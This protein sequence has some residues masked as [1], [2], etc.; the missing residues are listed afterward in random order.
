MCVCVCVCVCVYARP[1]A[2]VLCGS[3]A[4][5]VVVLRF[6]RTQQTLKPFDL[7]MYMHIKGR[8]QHTHGLAS[9]RTHA[10]EAWMQTLTYTPHT[11]TR[12]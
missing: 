3:M 7:Y 11:E 8:N 12:N 10:P 1:R 2:R 5:L 9:T 4:D 6:G